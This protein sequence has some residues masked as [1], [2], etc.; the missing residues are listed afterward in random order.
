MSQAPS[1]TLAVGA[2][3]VTKYGALGGFSG[4]MISPPQRIRGFIFG[5]PNA[6]KSNMLQNCPDAW[7]ANMDESSTVTPSVRATLFPGKDLEGYPIGDNGARIVADSDLY[8]PKLALLKE[9][10][11]KNLPRPKLVVFD[12]LTSW[13]R[14][15]KIWIPKNAKRLGI[16][17]SSDPRTTFEWKDLDGR[18]AWDVLYDHIVNTIVELSGLGYG[19]WL[20]GHVANEK[21]AIGENIFNYKPEL[22]ITAGFWKRL[23]DI[24]EL[25]AAIYT[26]DATEQYQDE[27]VTTIRGVEKKELRNRERTV[28][29]RYLSVTKLDLIGVMKERVPLPPRIELSRSDAWTDF[30]KAYKEAMIKASVK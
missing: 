4:Q 12:S 19:V 3:P 22:T 9:L 1:Q 13:I 25:V 26:E 27:I 18:A 24:F 28:K 14:L 11:T 17:S 20:I 8:V 7:I 30:E 10:A 15:L 21:I 2:L 16:V 6:G 5:Y 29:K 23:Q